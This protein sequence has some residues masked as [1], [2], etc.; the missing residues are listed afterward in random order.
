MHLKIITAKKGGFLLKFGNHFAINI[1]FANPA[2]D[3]PVIVADLK[4]VAIFHGGNFVQII[5]SHDFAKNHVIFFQNSFSS[6]WLDNCE[7]TGF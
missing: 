2:V 5:F 3:V 6:D 4:G 1:I 7:L